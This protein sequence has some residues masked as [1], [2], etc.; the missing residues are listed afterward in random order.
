MDTILQ[1][2]IPINYLVRETFSNY[3]IHR[4]DLQ[5][6]RRNEY[7]LILKEPEHIYVVVRLLCTEEG[8]EY[9]SG[10]ES[11]SVFSKMVRIDQMIFEVSS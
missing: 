3:A 5:L 1:L 6:P 9:L 2:E 11:C 8:F 7:D 4:F 10:I